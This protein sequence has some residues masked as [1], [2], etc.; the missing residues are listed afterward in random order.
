M[1]KVLLVYGLPID[2]AAT[3]IAKHLWMWGLKP[4]VCTEETLQ[5]NK[6]PLYDLTKQGTNF[7][8]VEEVTTPDAIR[9]YIYEVL[10]EY[11]AKQ[12]AFTLM[13]MQAAGS[14]KPNVMPMHAYQ[15]DYIDCTTEN[16]FSYLNAATA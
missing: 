16:L 3:R 9:M 7:L 15:Y 10:K 14:D 11:I 6:G 4:Y 2:G 5:R 13:I 12:K 1:N 8:I